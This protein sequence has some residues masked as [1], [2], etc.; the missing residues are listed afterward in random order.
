M[1]KK[2]KDTPNTFKYGN[3]DFKERDPEREL[4]A[5]EKMM[6]IA[7]YQETGG[8][9]KKAAAH[10]CISLENA[11]RTLW[12]EADKNPDV[13]TNPIFLKVAGTTL[14]EVAA[15]FFDA[16]CRLLKGTSLK[17]SSLVSSAVFSQ[18]RGLK[19][20]DA[21]GKAAGKAGTS[22]RM[23][24]LLGEQDEIDRELDRLGGSTAAGTATEPEAG[25][26]ATDSMGANAR[27][28]DE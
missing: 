12:A 15:E 16:S 20:L 18:G 25:S 1:P 9:I 27:S 26:A 5:T 28:Q 11:R 24:D 14:L 6:F 21:W 8:S 3:P 19:Y 10:L 7:R 13:L 23:E 17:P 22:K 2:S 4:D